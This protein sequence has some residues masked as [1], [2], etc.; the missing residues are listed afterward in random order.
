VGVFKNNQIILYLCLHTH[1]G[2]IFTVRF[3]V[4]VCVCPRVKLME[5]NLSMSTLRL[6]TGCGSDIRAVSPLNDI[7]SHC[8]GYSMP[9][10]LVM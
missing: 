3:I 1:K 2:L 5:Q 7:L 6:L 4:S 9:D 10:A 8:A